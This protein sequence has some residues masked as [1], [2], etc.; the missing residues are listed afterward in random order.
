MKL[1][2]D[3]LYFRMIDPATRMVVP[4]T[5]MQPKCYHPSALTSQDMVFGHDVFYT[6]Q[7]MRESTKSR[8]CGANA[9]FFTQ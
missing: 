1:C 7:A 5:D 8:V 9:Q 2:K 6:C 3:C 4:T